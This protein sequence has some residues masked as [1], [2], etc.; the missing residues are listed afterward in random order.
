[1]RFSCTSQCPYPERVDRMSALRAMAWCQY[2]L[3]T[4]AMLTWLSD[5]LEKVGITFLRGLENPKLEGKHTR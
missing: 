4:E 3:G 2:K 1:M 5:S